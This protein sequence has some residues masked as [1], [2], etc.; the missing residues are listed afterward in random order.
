MY[1]PVISYL[2][3]AELPAVNHLSNL[4]LFFIYVFIF[5]LVEGNMTVDILHRITLGFV[6]K[7]R[8]A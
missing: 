1:K 2:T 5:M 8:P 6:G 4:I 3:H 7:Q